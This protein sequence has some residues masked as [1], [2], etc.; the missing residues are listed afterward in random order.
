MIPRSESLSFILAR[1]MAATSVVVLM[2]LALAFSIKELVNK[3]YLQEATLNANA[4]A[5]AEAL[6]SGGQPALL[7]LYRDYPKAYG[8]RVF[9]HSALARR[10]VLAAANTGWFPTVPGSTPGMDDRDEARNS[11]TDDTKL[12]EGFVLVRGLSANDRSAPPVA[13]ATRRVGFADR[14]YWVQTYM[15]GDPAF[16]FTGVIADDLIK[17]ILVPALFIIPALT[18]AIFLTTR[19]VLRPLRQLSDSA[20]HVGAAVA[21]GQAL[22]PI[23][24]SGM[25]RE[26]ARVAATINVMLAKLD[27]S[28]QLQKQFTSDIAHELR[29]PLAVLLLDM[30]QLPPG[31]ARDRVKSDLK[32]LGQLV[33]ELLRFAQAEDV[34]ASEVGNVDIVAVARK[35]VEEAVPDALVKRQ[36]LELNCSTEILMLSGNPALLKIAIR[37][38]VDNALKYAPARTTVTVAVEPGP[39]VIVDDRGPGI[40]TEHRDRA[41]ARF[42]R[43]DR[44]LGCGAGV[45]LA[46]VRRIAQLHDGHIRMEQRPGGG[47][48]MILS[49]AGSA[50][51]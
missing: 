21:S 23:P 13:V 1:R 16:A 7:R 4:V 29:T 14:H 34:M 25:A 35:V 8:F 9:D 32:E 40:P 22:V 17:Q 3:R 48:R 38:L 44:Q 42:W 31:S 36:L 51:S 12:V 39:S 50:F 33:D 20:G 43:M 27:H 24:E 5:I 41:F 2:V 6:H 49:L 10:H 47:T 30:S 19:T 11:T 45:G 37:N 46:L 26:F 15:A 28:L 18:L